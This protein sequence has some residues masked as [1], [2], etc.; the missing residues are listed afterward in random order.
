MVVQ[1]LIVIVWIIISGVFLVMFI[2]HVC[3]LKL[4][5]NTVTITQ[6]P[7][8]FCPTNSPNLKISK[9]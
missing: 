5:R 4:V 3:I 2:E 9:K 7:L 8:C 1:G 6:N